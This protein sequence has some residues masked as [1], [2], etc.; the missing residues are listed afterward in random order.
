[1]PYELYWKGRLDAIFI[2]RDKFLLEQER[3]N[4][5]ID[6]NAWANGL[7]VEKALQSVYYMFNAFSGKNPKVYPYPNTSILMEHEKKA[8]SEK[9]L[10][11]L[12]ET[13][14]SIVEH[15]LI[16]RA[17]LDSKKNK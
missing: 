14:Q 11:K 4:K 6:F 2:Y 17:M 13:K 9:D 7:Y 12:E 10:K 3:R 8:R 15:N 5:E 1:M 16:I